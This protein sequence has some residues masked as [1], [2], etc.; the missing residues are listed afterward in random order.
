MSI[1]HHPDFDQHDEIAFFHDPESGLRAIVALHR[2]WEQPS[3]GGCRVAD[4]ATEDEALSDVLRLSSGMTKKSVMAGL[5]FGGAKAVI[6][7]VP[8]ESRRAAVM[9]AMARITHRFGGR[10]R[11]GVDL[12]LRPTDINLMQAETPYVFGNATPPPS[13]ATADGLLVSIKTAVRHKLARPG[14]RGVRVGVQG[15]GKVGM[16][17]ST[18]LVSEGATV[19]VGDIDGASAER[20]AD[21][22]GVEVIAPD[23][24]HAAEIDL[25]CPCARGGI[26]NDRTIAELEASMVVGAANNQLAEPRHG[27]ML[28]ERGVLYAPDYVVNAGGLIAVAAELNN[29]PEGWISE[30]L[31]GLAGTLDQLFDAA[32]RSNSCTALAADRLAEDRIQAIEASLRSA[33]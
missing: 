15:L 3:V 21:E 19:V 16:R 1:Q 25:F 6:I 13:H 32:E 17:L 20:A 12:G 30:K 2:S 14:L 23:R 27:E 11:T 24:I 28:R 9:R 29:R 4:Y 5:A 18:L 33:A 10:F 26:L 22:F 7:G 31:D 8:E